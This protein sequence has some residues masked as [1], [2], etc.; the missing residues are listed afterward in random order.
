MPKDGLMTGQLGDIC[1]L[2][3]S[4]ENKHEFTSLKLDK[5]FGPTWDR[6]LVSFRDPPPNQFRLVES[7]STPML[8]IAAGS[9]IAPFIGIG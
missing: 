4:A 7:I 6:V 9:G 5:P 8:L 3:A 2:L 1:R